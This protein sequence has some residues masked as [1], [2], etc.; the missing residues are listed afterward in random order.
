[1]F[2]EFLGRPE[3]IKH[4]RSCSNKESAFLSS[5]VI[6]GF[7]I[8]PLGKEI[9]LDKI[10]MASNCWWN[11]T[12]MDRGLVALALAQSEGVLYTLFMQVRVNSM[13]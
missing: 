10:E 11:L 5:R 12:R 2:I 4:Q 13:E 3:W 1:M 8:I 6:S 9:L 7:I